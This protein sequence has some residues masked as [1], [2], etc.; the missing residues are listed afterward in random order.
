MIP[1]QILSLSMHM[2]IIEMPNN[3]KLGLVNNNAHAEIRQIP[4]I[5][6]ILSGKQF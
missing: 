5:L 3:H 6:M 2:Q 4:S 1:T